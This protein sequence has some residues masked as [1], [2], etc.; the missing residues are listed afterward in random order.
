MDFTLLIETLGPTG[1][2]LGLGVFA[3]RA[4]MPLVVSAVGHLGKV[5]DAM[6]QTAMAVTVI[7]QK[8]DQQET[9]LER[10]FGEIRSELGDVSQDLA[11][12]Y[13]LQAKERPSRRRAP[14]AAAGD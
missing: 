14:A 12:L 2:I 9:V 6:Q 3:A 13:A 4:L 7:N 10:Q 1:A 5:A 11:G 8:L